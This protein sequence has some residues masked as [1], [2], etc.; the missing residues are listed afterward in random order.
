MK[1]IVAILLRNDYVVKMIVKMIVVEEKYGVK[2]SNKIF[3][4]EK[5]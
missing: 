5:D 1:K 3:K 2:K 4:S